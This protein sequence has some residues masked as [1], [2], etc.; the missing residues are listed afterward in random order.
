MADQNLDGADLK[1]VLRGGLIREDVMEQ[2]WD[3]TKI[4]L[5]FT[6]LIGS[7]SVGNS[8]AEW[9]QDSLPAPD[10]DNATI[11]GADAQDDDSQTGKRVGNHC[12]IPDKVVKVSTRARQSKTVG[13]A[14]TLAY[15]VMMRQISLRRDVEAIYLTNQASLAD[16]G[17]AIAGRLGALGAWLETNTSR[18]V[19]GADGGFNT[20]TGIVDAP[21][22]GT[23]RPLTETLLRDM[24]EACWIEG[25]NPTVGMSVPQQIRALSEYLF[26]SSARIATLQ[27]SEQGPASP[28]TAIGQ[29]NVFL[30][31]HGVVLT[32]VP[33]R[34][35]PLYNTDTACNFYILDPGLLMQGFLHGYQV[36]ELAKL[37]SADN[38]QMIVDVTLKVLQEAG[39]AVVADLDFTAPVTQV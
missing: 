35:Q 20:G 32:L 5:P 2:I 4:P 39:L 8:F 23:I 7:D 3:I 11:D 27:R 37:G 36:A 24:V 26:T 21:V 31:D 28:A 25:G 22:D 1:A 30:T 19:G 14:D 10:L 12:Q 16:D 18:G 17:S 9:T 15:Q 29:V 34:L 13:F 6:D 38:R 33:N